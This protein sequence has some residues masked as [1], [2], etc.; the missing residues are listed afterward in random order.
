MSTLKG[1]GASGFSPRHTHPRA[2]LD[3][4]IAGKHEASQ[5]WRHRAQGGH[6]LLDVVEGRREWVVRLALRH[7]PGQLGESWAAPV[8]EVG[9]DGQEG[10]AE[11]CLLFSLWPL[12]LNELVAKNHP[13]L[14]EHHLDFAKL[15]RVDW[16]SLRRMHRL[17]LVGCRKPGVRLAGAAELQLGDLAE[18][19][20]G[21]DLLELLR[22]A[23]LHRGGD[24]AELLLL[25]VGRRRLALGEKRV[26]VSHALAPVL[27][28]QRLEHA[29][30]LAGVVADVAV[31][32]GHNV[33]LVQADRPRGIFAYDN[34]CQLERLQV[35]L[36]QVEDSRTE[37]ELLGAVG[38]VCHVVG[39][40]IDEGVRQLARAVG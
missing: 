17:V 18:Q 4:L 15:V 31:P 22:P 30:R 20:I 34:P 5:G 29:P 11:P 6:L 37:R 25:H 8:V 24:G 19:L 26:L 10:L 2:P 27:L 9:H 39:D 28:N 35:Y 12:P 21:L 16:G 7:Y 32:L 13:E 14:A 33:E 3:A 38:A 23:P 1:H 40:D 36:V